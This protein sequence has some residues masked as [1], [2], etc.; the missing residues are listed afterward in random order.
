[1]TKF[2]AVR[3]NSRVRRAVGMDSRGM[4]KATPIKVVLDQQDCGL[5][6][7]FPPSFVGNESMKSSS[8]RVIVLS[9]IVEYSR[10]LFSL[11]SD[12]RR[13]NVLFFIRQYKAVTFMLS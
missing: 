7:E 8:I 1:M 2:N 13:F 11:R 9:S 4:T 10:S 6:E 3:R 12:I 5:F